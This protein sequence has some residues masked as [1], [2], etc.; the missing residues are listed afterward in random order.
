MNKALIVILGAVTLD[1]VGIGLI[2][3]ILPAL[4]RDVGHMSEVA[5]LLGILFTR[6]ARKLPLTPVT[7]TLLILVF[8]MNV[9]T[10]FALICGKTS[11]TMP[12]EIVCG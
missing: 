12:T 3:P 5:T 9:T 1:A 2:F 8:W 10:L 7:V 11:R 4:L 6:E